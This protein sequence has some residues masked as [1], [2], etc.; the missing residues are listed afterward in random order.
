MTSSK[1]AKSLK[2]AN[3]HHKFLTYARICSVVYGRAFNHK[4][5]KFNDHEMIFGTFGRAF[6]R[7]LKNETECVVVFRGTREFVMDWPTN[8]FC[9]PV[10]LDFNGTICRVHT[11]FLAGLMGRRTRHQCRRTYDVLKA[12]LSSVLNE[13]PVRISFIGHSLG[14]AYAVLAAAMIEAEYPNRVSEVVTF[15]QPA[16]GG[17]GFGNWYKKI[18]LHNR[19]TRLMHE[20]DIVTFLPGPRFEHVGTGWWSNGGKWL[21][22][23]GWHERIARAWGTRKVWQFYRDHSVKNYVEICRDLP[24]TFP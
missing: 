1:N 10:N 3:P 15:G 18:G 16:I 22:H 11:G 6:C 9:W 20:A 5:Y 13:T 21:S 19:T 12:E 17:R 7:I 23:L 2:Q 24:S 4:I 8:L 14:G